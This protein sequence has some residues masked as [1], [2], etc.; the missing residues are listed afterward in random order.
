MKV[1]LHPASLKL[2]ETEQNVKHAASLYISARL[3]SLHFLFHREDF[4]I[5]AQSTSHECV[6]LKDRLCM[7]SVTGYQPVNKKALSSLFL[8]CYLHIK[9][10]SV[11]L[12][13]LGLL[14]TAALVALELLSSRAT[15]A[16]GT[17][18]TWQSLSFIFGI[19]SQSLFNT[20]F[21]FT[22]ADRPDLRFKAGH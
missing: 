21:A 8:L 17:P 14:R 9:S 5:A 16:N 7:K 19:Y 18:F 13:Q 15:R 22:P 6:M 11:Q 2:Y 1:L 3:F 12:P 20:L 4:V 10:T